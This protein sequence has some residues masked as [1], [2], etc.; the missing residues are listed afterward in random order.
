MTSIKGC[1]KSAD[2]VDYLY[3]REPVKIGVARADL[4]DSVFAHENG[5]VRVVQDAPFQVW[6]FGNDLRENFS[7]S[8]GRKQHVGACAF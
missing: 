5:C 8:R 1:P 4:P 2:W 6:N 3:E 7:M